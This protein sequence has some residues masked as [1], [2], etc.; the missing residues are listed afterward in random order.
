MFLYSKYRN[1]VNMDF[2]SEIYVK[3]IRGGYAVEFATIGTNGKISKITAYRTET[4]AEVKE[5]L[6]MLAEHISMKKEAIFCFPDK[7]T[8]QT[9]IESVSYP[10]LKP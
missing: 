10:R 1:I 6:D 5:V 4:E 3:K 7:E 2:V 8:I 9:R